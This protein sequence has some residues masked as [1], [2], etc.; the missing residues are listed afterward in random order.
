M[1]TTG[2]AQKRVIP[3]SKLTDNAI[4]SALQNPL[5]HIFR[6]PGTYQINSVFTREPWQREKCGLMLEF[7]G[8]LVSGITFC[9]VFL[10]T[11]NP[12][13]YEKKFNRHKD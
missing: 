1:P 9:F 6:E 5:F 11:D 7:D 8:N 3:Q 12:Y 2:L 13:L 10:H 4:I